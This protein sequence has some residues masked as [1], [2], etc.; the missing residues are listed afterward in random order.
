LSSTCPEPREDPAGRTRII[1]HRG[2]SG[3]LPEHT[4]AAKSLAYG[5]GVDFVEQDVVATKDHELVVLHDIYLDDVSDVATR[6]AGK[7]REDG[8]FYV[9]DFT[10][11][12]IE[13][14]N[15]TERRIPGSDER[16]FAGRFPYDIGG[17]KVCRLVDEIRLIAGLNKATGRQVGLYPEIKDP[18]WHNAFGIDLT[19]LLHDSLTASRA[20]LSGPIFVQSFDATSIRRLKDELQTD[21]PLVQLLNREDADRLGEGGDALTELLE[22]ADGVGLPYE[23]LIEPAVVNGRLCATELARKLGDT[24]LLVHPYTMRRDQDPPGEIG[25]FEA[26]AF[27]IHDLQVDALFCDHPDDALAVRDCSAA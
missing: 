26:L 6:F 19:R 10:L 25:Y 16:R 20:T 22:Y 27:L 23:S 15:L 7:R 8:H 17:L 11:S 1:A 12:E 13:A 9:V 18:A 5:L 4:A 14:L 2:A 24:E 3:Y 21:L